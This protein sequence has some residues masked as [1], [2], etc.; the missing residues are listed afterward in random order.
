MLRRL[1]SSPRCVFTNFQSSANGVGRHERLR[2]TIPN[3]LA[4][5]RAFSAAAAAGATKKMNLFTALNDAMDVAMKTVWAY[6]RDCRERMPGVRVR[7]RE[8]EGT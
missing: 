3:T 2:A 8:R 5:S 1:S 7:E 4:H 6:A